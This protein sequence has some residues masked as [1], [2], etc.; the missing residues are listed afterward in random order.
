MKVELLFAL[1]NLIT[2]SDKGSSFV[3]VQLM[4]LYKKITFRDKIVRSL[5]LYAQY[6]TIL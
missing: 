6:R 3:Y 1:K 4:N 5:S 2:I